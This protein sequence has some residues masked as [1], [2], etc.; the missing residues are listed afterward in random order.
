MG[1]TLVRRMPPA[2]PSMAQRLDA[3]LK[4][5]EVGAVGVLTA[6]CKRVGLDIAQLPGDFEQ[7]AKKIEARFGKEVALFLYPDGWDRRRDESVEFMAEIFPTDPYK[8]DRSKWVCR[9]LVPGGDPEEDVEGWIY[10]S[11][12]EAMVAAEELAKDLAEIHEVVEG[13]AKR[14]SEVTDG[15]A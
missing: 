4:M 14:E 1:D 9:V 3:L 12:D 13:M 15:T 11:A 8:D 7:A 10:D 6:I 2:Q 5:S